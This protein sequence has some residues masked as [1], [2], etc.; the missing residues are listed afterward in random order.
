MSDTYQ[1]FSNLVEKLDEVADEH[2]DQ[3]WRDEVNHAQ[4]ILRAMVGYFS[5]E[6]T[7]LE[8]DQMLIHMGF[9]MPFRDQEYVKDLRDAPAI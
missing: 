5:E 2:D 1:A 6:G 9:E 7:D 4:N 8:Q 3:A